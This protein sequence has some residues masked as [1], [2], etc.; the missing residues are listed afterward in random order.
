MSVGGGHQDGIIVFSEPLERI[1]GSCVRSQDGRRVRM[2]DLTG[3]GIAGADNAERVDSRRALDFEGTMGC[4]AVSEANTTS[5]KR[6][7]QPTEPLPI[8]KLHSE[9]LTSTL[10]THAHSLPS[11]HARPWA[12]TTSVPATISEAISTPGSPDRTHV[13]HN[14]PNTAPNPLLDVVQSRTPSLGRGALYAG[15]VFKGTQTSGR[16]AYEVEVKIL[17]SPLGCMARIEYALMG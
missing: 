5:D 17:V 7:L 6:E 3:L 1:C 4:P 15:S 9:L 10:H 8:P 16:S 13:K 12:T 14:T 2:S 11:Q